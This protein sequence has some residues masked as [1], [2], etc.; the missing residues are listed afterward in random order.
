MPVMRIAK[1]P[2]ATMRMTAATRRMANDLRNAAIM[3]R[4]NL[5]TATL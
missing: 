5:S 3:E 1:T 2:T 4:R